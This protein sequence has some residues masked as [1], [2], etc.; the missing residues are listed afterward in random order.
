MTV[1]RPI[2]AWV[3]ALLSGTPLSQ[4]ASITATINNTANWEIVV[5]VQCQFSNVSADPVI[6]IYSSNDGGVT[7]DSVPMAAF[8]ITRVAAGLGGASIRLPQGIYALRI[9]NSGPNTATFFINT[10]QVVTAVNNV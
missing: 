3:A 5:P 1:S 9:I 2:L 4:S 6:N 7:F 10:Q 8:A